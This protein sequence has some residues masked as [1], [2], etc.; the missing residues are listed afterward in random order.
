MLPIRAADGGI[1]CSS[2]LVDG[3]RVGAWR[4][5]SAREWPLVWEHGGLSFGLDAT[6]MDDQMLS[7][8]RP[9]VTSN[10]EFR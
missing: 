3:R 5:G 4:Y 7:T 10:K 8:G 9:S 6:V 1:P 2:V